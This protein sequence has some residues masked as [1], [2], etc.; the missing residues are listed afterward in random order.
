MV[1]YYSKAWLEACAETLNNSEKHLKKARKLNG[2]PKGIA[3]ALSEEFSTDV[4]V[5]Q[6]VRWRRGDD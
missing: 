6:V 2:P 5:A 3:D 4:T 1:T